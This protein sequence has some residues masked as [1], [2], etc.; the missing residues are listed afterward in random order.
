[1]VKPIRQMSM[2]E[3][4]SEINSWRE[5]MKNLEIEFDKIISFVQEVKFK[6]CGEQ[7]ELNLPNLQMVH[8]KISMPN[9]VCY[10]IKENNNKFTSNEIYKYYVDD[11]TYS[12]IEIS[13]NIIPPILSK[14]KSEGY[15]ENDGPGKPWRLLKDYDK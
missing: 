7:L 11:S 15:I 6:I 9:R 13:K 2:E 12:K 14:L 1:M 5:R 3:I 8:K 4:E 10:L